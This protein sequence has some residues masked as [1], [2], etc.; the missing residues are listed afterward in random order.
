ML[1]AVCVKNYCLAMLNVLYKGVV[2]SEGYF[3]LFQC[4]PVCVYRLHFR[5]D[6]AL[7]RDM[8]LFFMPFT[9]IS[10]LDVDFLSIEKR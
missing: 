8:T 9:F 6:A 5:L 7:L 2:S 10:C 3:F 1:D 4:V